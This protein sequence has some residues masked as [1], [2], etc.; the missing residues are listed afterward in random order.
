MGTAVGNGPGT[1]RRTRGRL[2]GPRPTRPSPGRRPVP[3]S[4]LTGSRR[5]RVHCLCPASVPSSSRSNRPT[6]PARPRDDL[7]RSPPLRADVQARHC[8]PAPF[9]ERD[10]AAR[11]RRGLVSDRRLRPP[12]AGRRPPRPSITW[13]DEANE[14]PPETECDSA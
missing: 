4:R 10:S 6:P 2:S 1:A 3:T 12:G 11:R 8:A 13:S 5:D 7:T 14:I 9:I